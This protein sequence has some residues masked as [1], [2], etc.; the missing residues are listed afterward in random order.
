HRLATDSGSTIHGPNLLG[1]GSATYSCARSP[2]GWGTYSTTAQD[3]GDGTRLW[4]VQEYANSSTLCQWGTRVVGFNFGVA[5]VSKQDRLLV[6][7]V[8]SD[9]AWVTDQTT[10]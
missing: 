7:A 1:S 4:T 3:G 2:V 6:S 5:L 10:S 9:C 8:G